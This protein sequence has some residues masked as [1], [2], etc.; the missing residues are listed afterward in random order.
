MSPC[1]SGNAEHSARWHEDEELGKAGS[2]ALTGAFG[3][4][5]KSLSSILCPWEHKLYNQ[6]GSNTKI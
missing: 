1:A 2:S 3:P 6:V 5:R 4:G